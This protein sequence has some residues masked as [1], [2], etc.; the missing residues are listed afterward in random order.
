MV[1]RRNNKDGIS[2]FWKFMIILILVSG[3]LVVSWF[4]WQALENKHFP[5]EAKKELAEKDARLEQLK[6]ELSIIKS[7]ERTEA[8]QNFWKPVLITLF[9]VSGVVALIFFFLRRKNKNFSGK[10]SLDEAKTKVVKLCNDVMGWKPVY[11][12][13]SSFE[14]VVGRDFLYLLACSRTPRSRSGVVNWKQVKIF[15]VV[16][17][18]WDSRRL[19]DLPFGRLR[20]EDVPRFLHENW[21]RY[22]H[23]F[24]RESKATM[25]EALE[26]I[27]KDREAQNVFYDLL[28]PEGR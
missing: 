8:L 27:Q 17:G 21:D 5:D 18:D 19:E 13:A 23:L 10:I 28:D 2:G 15:G 26:Q 24:M 12:F 25:R 6:K 7:D 1:R 20:F 9:I 11:V 3:V 22:G 16:S 14:R 4:A